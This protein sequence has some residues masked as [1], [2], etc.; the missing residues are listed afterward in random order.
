MKKKQVKG[1]EI[2]FPNTKFSRAYNKVSKFL[3]NIFK[4]GNK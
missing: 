2:A 1:A 3:R 4:S